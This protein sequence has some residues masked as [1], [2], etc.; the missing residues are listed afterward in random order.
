MTTRLANDVITLT[1]GGNTVRL[2]PSLRA[3][4][5][6]ERLHD[7]FEA[8]FNRVDAF[9]TSTIREII[10]VS[11]TDREDADAYL[12]AVTNAP[13]RTLHATR[14]QIIT[15]CT[16][17]IPTAPDQ[18]QSKPE[19]KPMPWAEVYARLYKIATGWLG[20]TPNTAWAATPD[21]IAHAFDGLTE[22]LR[23][24]HGSADEDEAN[25]GPDEEQR[26]ANEA[27]GLDPDFDRDG[28]HKL[29]AQLA[30]GR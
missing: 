25:T 5:H 17:L 30:G 2:R 23:A 27:A 4:T 10:W 22:K 26:A 3:A 19:G 28:L 29:K 16:S 21:E 1:H 6:L 14:N 20:W 7:G 15:L 18:E 9:D 8:L 13:L 24:I 11:A 12:S